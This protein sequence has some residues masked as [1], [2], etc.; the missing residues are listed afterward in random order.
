MRAFAK[1]ANFVMVGRAFQYAVAA[2]GRRGI[3]HLIHIL[4]SDINANMS[5]L[6]AQRLDQLSEHLLDV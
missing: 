4:R 5:Q 3:D 1:G 2:F 6:G